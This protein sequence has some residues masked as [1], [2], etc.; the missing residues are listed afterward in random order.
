MMYRAV[1]VKT[2]SPYGKMYM[3]T[4]KI[5]PTFKQSDG[6]TI[7]TFHLYN[8]PREREWQCTLNERCTKQLERKQCKMYRWRAK[9]CPNL[10]TEQWKNNPHVQNSQ[11]VTEWSE[12][13][14]NEQYTEQLVAHIFS[15]Y[16]MY[17]PYINI[18]KNHCNFWMWKW[19]NYL[20]ISIA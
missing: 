1:I 13:L 6:G 15:P 11:R 12:L 4:A 19:R 14:T 17:G 8:L 9:Y 10:Q 5:T 18:A 20:H 2:N 3:Q 16:K 7:H